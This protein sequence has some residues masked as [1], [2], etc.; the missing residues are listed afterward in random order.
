M[1]IITHERGYTKILASGKLKHADYIKHL[2]PT[3]EKLAKD[4]DFRVMVVL[5]DMHGIELKAILDDLKFYIKNR[6]K[7]D[8]IV[9]MSNYLFIDSYHP[10]SL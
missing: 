8:K 7:F 10:L 6:R 4:S 3:I 5:N 1:F 2:V 9:F